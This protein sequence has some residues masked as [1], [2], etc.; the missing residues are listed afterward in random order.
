MSACVIPEDY[1]HDIGKE[2][3]RKRALDKVW[4][5]EGYMCQSKES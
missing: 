3:A 1:N 2:Y 4:E 5:L